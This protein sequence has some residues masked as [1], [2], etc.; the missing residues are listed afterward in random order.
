MKSSYLFRYF[1]ALLVLLGLLSLVIGLQSYFKNLYKSSPVVIEPPIET[2][3]SRLP[4]PENSPMPSP[5][6]TRTP[7]S[8]LPTPMLPSLVTPTP[9]SLL[10]TPEKAPRTLYGHYPYAQHSQGDLVEV[11][12]YYGRKEYMASEAARVF[13]A[14]QG[15]ARQQGVNLTIISGFRSINDQEQ[16]F[17]KQIQRRGS[18]EAAARLSA[19]PGHSEHH[20][21]Y[22]ID[23]GDG[24][25]PKLD[26]KYEFE[27]SPA[28]AWLAN[29]GYKYGFELSFPRGNSQG[30]NFEPWHWRYVGSKHASQ[31]FADA[32][33]N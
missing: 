2:P 15:D 16:L 14:M 29:N 13:Q 22:A 6:V 26:L 19:P 5:S 17:A 27:S 24:D 4:T 10:P 20:T 25:N 30:V 1:Q 8:R 9:G 33:R 23:I 7:G 18:N 31:I 21:G 12:V 11:G 28:Y 32:R 3:G